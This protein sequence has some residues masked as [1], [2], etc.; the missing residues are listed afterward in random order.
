[1]QNACH[2]H[3]VYVSFLRICEV[4]VFVYTYRHLSS[5]SILGRP[6]RV[7]GVDLLKEHCDVLKEL[8]RHARPELGQT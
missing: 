7:L 6:I 2:I 8:E 3:S 5:E 4:R 1:M